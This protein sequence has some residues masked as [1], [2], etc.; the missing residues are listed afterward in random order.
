MAR[1]EELKI[2]HPR[3][4]MRAIDGFHTDANYLLTMARN[5][6]S[7]LVDDSLDAE[8]VRKAISPQLQEA[9]DRVAKWY[10]AD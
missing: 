7:F 6:H 2:V 10:N 8:K 9:I 4:A 3:T 1:K 5:A